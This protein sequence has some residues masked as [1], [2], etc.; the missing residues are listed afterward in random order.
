MD[1]WAEHFALAADGITIK[2]QTEI[3][4][5]TARI[6]GFNSEERLLEREALRAVGR[7]PTT[8]AERRPLGS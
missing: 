1:Q 6:L 8:A 3:G 4:E 2:P 7:Y 5:V